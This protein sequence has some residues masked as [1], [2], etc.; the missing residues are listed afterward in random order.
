MRRVT[1]AA[2][3]PLPPDAPPG[4][5]PRRFDLMEVMRHDAHEGIVDLNRHLDRMKESADALGFRFDRHHA[6]NELQAGT[7]GMAHG[8]VRLLLAMSGAVAVE[9]RPLPPRPEEPVSVALAEPPFA[10]DDPRVRHRTS[11]DAAL[12]EARTRAAAFEIVF[13][14]A[15]GLIARG[16][17][18][19]VFV[20]RDGV[21]LTPP[22]GEAYRRGI[23]RARLID[24]GRAVEAELTA[25]DLA[26]GFLIGNAVHGLLEARLA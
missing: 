16:S 14:D 6:R 24:E 15:A 3:Q 11:D 23:L 13:L 26:S 1:T 10:S 12:D 22:L 7:F 19:T 9:V 25:A 8:Q 17:F 21:L 5:V 2:S 4:A 20:E 18:T